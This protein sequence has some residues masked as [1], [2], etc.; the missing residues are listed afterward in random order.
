MRVMEGSVP[1]FP[2]YDVDEC[3]Q[4]GDAGLIMPPSYTI[5]GNFVVPCSTSYTGRLGV[6]CSTAVWGRNVDILVNNSSDFE[7]FV[8]VL[9]DWNHDGVWGGQDSCGTTPVPEHVLVDFLV[10]PGFNQ[11]LS[12]LNPPSF[13][14][15][16]DTGYFWT[17]FTICS[18][19]VG[20]EWTGEGQFED[21]ETEDYLLWVSES[22]AGAGGGYE[23]PQF[24][25][26]TSNP[27]PF[28]GKT[29]VSFEI[30][31]DQRVRLA[32]YDAFGRQVK[33]LFD[34]VKPAGE[35]ET[36][37]DGTDAR[38]HHVTPGMYF[39][40]MESA[41]YTRTQRLVLIR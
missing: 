20:A 5:V 8:N 36:V 16:P 24:K 12:A 15:G 32:V 31:Y 28:T 18:T 22:C 34:T 1:P 38:G 23:P 30:P 19:P 17:R 4:D 37:W 10:P 35:H 29:L 25:L 2:S 41:G 6:P 13:V 21:G 26:G 9:V 33:L 40:R 39:L 11:P 27:N 7:M 14:I 3:F